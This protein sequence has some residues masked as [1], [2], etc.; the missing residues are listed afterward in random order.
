MSR[1][2]GTRSTRS[3]HVDTDAEH[4]DPIFESG[5]YDPDHGYEGVEGQH[6]PTASASSSKGP[7]LRLKLNRPGSSH[8]PAASESESESRHQEEDHYHA[9]D[10]EAGEEEDNMDHPTTR[11]LRNRNV[12]GA[13]DGSGS[14][15]SGGLEGRGRRSS[16][17]SARGTGRSGDYELDHVGVNGNGNSTRR[18]SSRNHSGLIKNEHVHESGDVNGMFDDHD[19]DQNGDRERDQHSRKPRQARGEG[20][21]EEA[22]AATI[23]SGRPKRAAAASNRV[24]QYQD[25]YQEG[26]DE[27]EFE[28]EDE[29]APGEDDVDMEDGAGNEVEED[30][31][32]EEREFG[33][34]CPLSCIQGTAAG[35]LSSL[36]DLSI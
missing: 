4:I 6:P 29:D 5:E 2:P 30:E 36:N 35:F 24:G 7:K 11:R 31:D 23:S 13:S 32:E 9:N 20:G 17:G 12:S 10:D 28:D 25:G 27:D 18:R 22:E 3:H 33:L 16:N 19:P 1:Q 34:D 15:V 26:D 8:G 21:G 14:T